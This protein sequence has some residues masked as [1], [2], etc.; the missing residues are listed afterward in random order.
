MENEGLTIIIPAY[1][2]ED[3]IDLVV[4]QL[5]AVTQKIDAKC[6]IMV[7]NDGSSDGTA[8]IL[9]Q[10]HEIKVISHKENRGYGASLKTGLR[11]AK[12][13]LICITDADGT[14]PNEVIP[15]LCQQIV[16]GN[17]DM[18]VGARSA[19]DFGFFRR[20]AKWCIRKLAE[21]ICNEEIPDFNSGLRIFKKSVALD[22]LSLLPDGFSFTTTITVS[23][24]NN[25]Y[26]LCF[27]PIDYFPRLGRSKIRPVRDTKNFLILVLRM[28]L[29]FQ[30]IKVFFPL[31]ILF[32]LLS[33]FWGGFTLFALG[34]LADV[35]TMLLFLSSIQIGTVGLLAELIDKRSQNSYRK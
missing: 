15:R 11:N 24:L 30:P 18:V 31:S 22:F 3:G 7:V 23:M 33:V 28:A 1:N 16:N 34:K 8:E 35:T 2:E 14:Y 21:Y 32:F 5:V 4:S 26:L 10:M 29:Y 27:V 13:D 9:S 19:S 17:Y 20:P 25:G 6:E 12:Y